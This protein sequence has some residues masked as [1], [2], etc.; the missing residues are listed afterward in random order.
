MHKFAK[1]CKKAAS[2]KA[3]PVESSEYGALKDKKVRVID[4][5][6]GASAFSFVGT[7][8]TH[9]DDNLLLRADGE[10]PRHLAVKV[11][12]VEEMEGLKAA[13]PA[14]RMTFKI[15]ERVEM[16]M[17][18]DA[19]ELKETD[20]SKDARLASI[21]ID[22]QWWL[23]VRD[24]SPP[25]EVVYLSPAYTAEMNRNLQAGEFK[26][27]DG[28]KATVQAAKLLVVPVWAAN[29][30]HWT[31]L[32]LQ[33]FDSGWQARYRDSM[34]SGTP[35]KDCQTAARSLV[36]RLEL[37]FDSKIEL[38]SELFNGARQPGG[39]IVCGQ[40][41]CHWMELELRLYKGEG[42]AVSYP[43]PKK[44]ADRLKQLSNLIVKNSGVAEL[45]EKEKKACKDAEAKVEAQKAEVVKSIAADAKHQAETSKL[46]E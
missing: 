39:S 44:I 31:L 20:L 34:S 14:S 21:H 22:M 17:K 10:K 35:H 43:D 45:K 29:P 15:A 2:A 40:F 46:A 33:K 23:L 7:V 28:L 11:A 24:L 6:L 3:K 25:D 19:L 12:Q 4:E 8:V 18:F 37:A 32:V 13:T 1:S 30:M 5:K 42:H 41:V 27:L 36:S 26:C 16:D 38:P 9:I